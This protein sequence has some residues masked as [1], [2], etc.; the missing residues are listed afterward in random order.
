MIVTCQGQFP[1]LA[2]IPP[3]T[4]VTGDAPHEPGTT[5]QSINILN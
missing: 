2:S 5:I 4:R 3:M 1:G